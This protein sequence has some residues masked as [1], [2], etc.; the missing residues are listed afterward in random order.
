MIDVSNA[1]VNDLVND[2]DLSFVFNNFD[3]K[4]IWSEATLKKSS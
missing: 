4:D 2:N 3:L 1:N